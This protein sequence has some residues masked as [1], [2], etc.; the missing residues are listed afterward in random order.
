MGIKGLHKALEEFST[1]GH[2]NMFENQRVAIDAY[3]WLHKVMMRSVIDTVLTQTL[4]TIIVLP[5][6]LQGSYGCSTE[7]CLGQPTTK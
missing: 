6:C 5:H 4:F 3:A 2:V 7:L 1:E